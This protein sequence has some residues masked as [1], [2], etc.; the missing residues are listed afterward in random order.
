MV[1]VFFSCVLDSK[2]IDDEIKHEVGRVV[3]PEIGCMFYWCVSISGQV[4]GQAVAV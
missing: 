1:R 2:I 3:A 4:F